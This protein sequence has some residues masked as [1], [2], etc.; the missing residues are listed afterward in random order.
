LQ[1][2]KELLLE[3]V[4]FTGYCLIRRTLCNDLKPV[5]KSQIGTTK[6]K[7]QALAVQQSKN[8]KKTQQRQRPRILWSMDK[9]NMK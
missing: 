2:V 7:F 6:V 3:A 5:Y 1:A 8:D 4:Y 9:S